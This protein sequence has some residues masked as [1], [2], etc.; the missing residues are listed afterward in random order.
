MHPIDHDCNASVYI[1]ISILNRD[2]A[3]QCT[4]GSSQLSSASEDPLANPDLHWMDAD[5]ED[6]GT[7]DPR[8]AA[9]H[10]ERQPGMQLGRILRLNIGL[11]YCC[12]Y[13]HD[14]NRRD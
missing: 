11:K 9:F 12:C 8:I 6:T 7:S 2:L 1:F 14:K 10:P 5:V 13:L 4:L 3:S